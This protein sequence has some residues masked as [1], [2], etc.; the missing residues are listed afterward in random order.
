ML[1]AIKELEGMMRTLDE[2]ERRA[3]AQY[4]GEYLEGFCFAVKGVKK[5]IAHRLGELRK[6]AAIIG[7]GLGITV[8]SLSIVL[9]FL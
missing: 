8:L 9:L 5:V 7:A 6:A 2:G 3:H 1:K 4:E